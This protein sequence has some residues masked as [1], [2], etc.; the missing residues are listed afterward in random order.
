MSGHVVM[1]EPIAG[2]GPWLQRLHARWLA[3]M[4]TG[5]PDLVQI[6]LGN[7]DTEIT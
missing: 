5:L 6:R 1:L 7:Y 3:D 4:F 2:L